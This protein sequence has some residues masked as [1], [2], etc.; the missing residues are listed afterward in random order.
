MNIA[1]D[2]KYSMNLLKVLPIKL[3]PVKVKVP[4][5][6]SVSRRRVV[7]PLPINK[8]TMLRH[9]GLWDACPAPALNSVITPAAEIC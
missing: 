4:I 9:Q 3:Q 2:K 1:I 8:Y 6:K 5:Q 7:L